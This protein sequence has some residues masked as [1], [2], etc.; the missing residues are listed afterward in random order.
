MSSGEE[1]ES[2]GSRPVIA[3]VNVVCR[4]RPL[5]EVE[6]ESASKDGGPPFACLES[7][8]VE[9]K[10]RGTLYRRFDTLLDM[11]SSQRRVYEATARGMVNE[12][13]DGYNAG[14]FAYGQSGG[15]KTYSMLGKE[16]DLIGDLRGIVPRAMSDLFFASKRMTAESNGGVEVSTC[17]S[18]LEIY[19]DELYDLLHVDPQGNNVK[20]GG[21]ENRHLAT[22]KEYVVENEAEANKVV[23]V[24]QERRRY[25]YMPLNPVSSRS[26]GV[27]MLK[28]KKR[29]AD[30]SVAVSAL[31]FVDLMGSEALV[32]DN[33]GS[34]DETTTINLDLLTLGKVITLLGKNKKLVAPPYRDSTLTWVLRDVLGG[35]CKSTVLVTCSPHQ[36]QYTATQ[37][38]LEFGDQ[39]KGIQRRINQVEKK[40]NVKELEAVVVQ[41]RQALALKT[42]E[43]SNA[44]P[45]DETRD[46]IQQLE[47]ANIEVE[48]QLR[49]AEQKAAQTQQQADQC[50]QELQQKV[51]KAE[52]AKAKAESRLSSQI[53]AASTLSEEVE[54]L[55]KAVREAQG[56]EVLEGLRSKMHKELASTLSP[57]M[58]QGMEGPGSVEVMVEELFADRE[59]TAIKLA[60][61]TSMLTQSQGELESKQQMIETLQ[62]KSTRLQESYERAGMRHQS[63]MQQQEH[64]RN[65]L[66]E[67]LQQL[68]GQLEHEQARARGEREGMRRALM[69]A[70]H[71]AED[72]EDRAEMLCLSPRHGDEGEALGDSLSDA[73]T[74]L[75]DRLTEAR[76]EVAGLKAKEMAVDAEL[77]SVHERSAEQRQ[78]LQ[79]VLSREAASL[80][81]TRELQAEAEQ[82]RSDMRSMGSEHDKLVQQL[83]KETKALKQAHLEYAQEILILKQD[84][85]VSDRANVRANKISA[86][87]KFAAAALNISRLSGP[88]EMCQDPMARD[89]SESLSPQRVEGKKT[90]AQHAR[91]VSEVEM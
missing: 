82:T 34:F 13:L 61:A 43:C 66:E 52:A 17:I 30:T 7:G 91:K 46:M 58:L 62:E 24:G 72:A 79:Q 67:Q 41:L 73:L 40:L 6:L 54:A 23:M 26:H 80:K 69:A 2:S 55:R 48:N 70:E 14:M 12:V 88:S 15:G 1:N 77:A 44:A 3:G 90:L 81:H 31:Y 75:K 60:H 47:L 42:L 9:D 16:G 35:N 45:S 83:H 63:Q 89:R 21:R 59:A 20:L 38:T 49:S 53:L 19:K 8:T 10:R 68:R 4:F 50:N 37:N 33:L 28:V 32:Q 86:H 87:S 84:K 74:R 18:F 25:A 11:E 76:D 56:E 78:E 64:R 5:N 57:A 65:G 36:M 29:Y 22:L 71:D 51:D 85:L 39:C 27:L